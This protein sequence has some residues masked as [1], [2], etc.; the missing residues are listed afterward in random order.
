MPKWK[1]SDFDSTMVE[2]S[3]TPRE[4]GREGGAEE[5][6]KGGGWDFPGFQFFALREL[7]ISHVIDHVIGLFF[8]RTSRRPTLRE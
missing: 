8:P 5:R 2:L 7:F 6:R 4:E 1:I 3:I